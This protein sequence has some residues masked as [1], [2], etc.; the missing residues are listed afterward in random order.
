MR[1]V[2]AE[3]RAVTGGA[4][5]LREID[6]AG[7]G[8]VLVHVGVD[9][10]EPEGTYDRAHHRVSL[11]QAAVLGERLRSR[12]RKLVRCLAFGYKN[13]LPD[14]ATWLVD[15]RFLDNPYRRDDLRPL[16]G[17]HPA[18]R[19]FVLGQPAAAELLD[20]LEGMLAWSIPLYDRDALTLAIGCTGGRHRSVALAREMAR[21]LEAVGGIDV[22]FAARDI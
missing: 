17:L 12:G 16:D 14:E 4:R 11:D 8:Y 22:E 15:A 6:R 5:E 9:D 1:A 21:R 20:R 3:A 19:D 18:V 13:G 7:T 10:G 2:G